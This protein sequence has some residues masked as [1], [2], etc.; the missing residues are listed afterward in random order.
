MLDRTEP[1]AALEGPVSREQLL[2]LLGEA[3][4]VEHNLM[5]CY[6]YAAF[7]LK[8]DVTEGITPEQ[9]EALAGWRRAIIGIA[10]E[11]MGHLAL[12]A[13]LTIA[14]GGPA[15][16]S[17]L[18][19]PISAG[20]LPADMTVRLAPFSMETLDHFIYL[21]RPEGSDVEDSAHFHNENEYR[22]GPIEQTRLMPV[23]QDYPTVGAFYDQIRHL[24]DVLATKYGEEELFVGSPETQVGPRVTP[25]PGLM[26]IAN[27]ADAKLAL[28]TIVEQGEGASSDHEEG[29]FARFCAVKREYEAFLDADPGFD[30]ARPVAENPV[31]RE[32][33]TPEGKVWVR[34]EDA[35]TVM[36][37][38][39]ALY[40]Q[41]L[42][43][44]TQAFGRSG[45]DDEKRV[46][47][48]A[49]TDLMHAVTAA[50]TAMT[51]MPANES[52]GANAGMS[53][54]M[55]WSTAAL[56]RDRDL[57]VLR[58]RFGELVEGAERLS[59][60]GAEVDKAVEITR[61]V[62]GAFARE[63]ARVRANVTTADGVEPPTQAESEDGT[64]WDLAEV[65]PAPEAPVGAKSV[66]TEEGESAFVSFDTGRCIHARQCVLGAPET[67]L[68]GVEGQW[69]F[70]DRT[71][72]D[73]LVAVT[74]RC[75]SGAVFAKRKDE[76]HEETAPPV[77]T[78]RVREDGPLA[79][80]GELVIDG[81]PDGYRRT[82]CRCGL[83]GAKPYCDGS[84][85]R[86]FEATGEPPEREEFMDRPKIR[87]GPLD[88]RPLPNGPLQVS[89]PLEVIKGTGT[90]IAR[91]ENARLCRCGQSKRKPFCDNSHITAGFKAP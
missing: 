63:V 55:T 64:T 18:N 30:P 71:Q 44:L 73:E 1:E 29:H 26:T 15:N 28:D 58:S 88:I 42:R 81:R 78:V 16:F 66:T 53:F 43:L 22:R 84:H 60:I 3:A 57:E 25:L 50:A 51:R 4:E 24:I 90:A 76:G 19:F 34:A 65:H 91:V 67:F 14:V 31:S 70:P 68:S 61:Y 54:A 89:G 39:N 62:A 10:I 5:C 46:L 36:D 9:V 47:V 40:L 45:G 11:E 6:L 8:D 49:A 32:P 13:N 41:M 83:S 85:T 69:L 56:P 7:S 23:A 20:A 79:F 82:L 33:P 80:H 2:A 17:R 86:G 27:L 87:N 21:E 37:F 59:G 75:P 52:S 72:T 38:V 77:N 48:V 35:A 12:V 74:E